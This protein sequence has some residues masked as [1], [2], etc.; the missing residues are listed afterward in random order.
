MEINA[1]KYFDES[2]TFATNSITE[3][4]FVFVPNNNK[5]SECKFLYEGKC[6]DSC[7]NGT[8]E[9]VDPN[10]QDICELV[11]IVVKNT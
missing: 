9:V 6:V 10:K 8:H 5:S 11:V 3:E 2:E 4:F 7:P 1:T